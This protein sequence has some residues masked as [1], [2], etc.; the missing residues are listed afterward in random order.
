[1]IDTGQRSTDGQAAILTM[2]YT[3]DPFTPKALDRTEDIRHVLAAS[4]PGGLHV[5]VGDG[6]A[7]RLDARIA[8]S[9]D[10]K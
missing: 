6:S 3:D 8:Q 5:L 2:I 7:E 1:M 10:T 4:A 9:R